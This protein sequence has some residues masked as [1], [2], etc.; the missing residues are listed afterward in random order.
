MTLQ[1]K[2]AD[3]EQ[4][5]QLGMLTDAQALSQKA[6]VNAQIY[7]LDLQLEQREYDLKR[8]TL[9]N[10]RATYD[11]STEKYR[12]YTRQLEVLAQQHEDKMRVIR[13]QTVAKERADQQALYLAQ[14]Q[15]MRS[16]AQGWAQNL[17]RMATLQQGFMATVKGLWQSLVSV[18]ANVLEQI[19]EKWLAAHLLK[20]AL[21]K[22]EQ[23]T[24]IGA[25]V[26][27]AGAGGVASMA[28]AP[29]PLN[30]TAPGFGAAMAAAA[31]A[32]GALGVVSAS[33]GYDVPAWPGAGIDGRGGQMAVLHP[34]EVVLPPDIADNFR[35]G[36]GGNVPPIIIQALDGHSVKRV[37][38]DN[39]G[40]LA[41][42][43]RKYFRD[44][45]R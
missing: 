44:G 38:M 41:E 27:K 33:G 21:S 6:K 12:E 34:R 31:G 30:L 23:K 25:E 4:A 7:A 32:F 17:A 35:N 1:E 16:L 10:E 18:I 45:G 42:A 15:N 14:T 3:I 20:L 8:Q 13:G 24:T 39:K 9:L 40:P 11:Q 2:L 43:L 37:L 19:I 22:A 29:F 26:S 28:A 36:G 5:H